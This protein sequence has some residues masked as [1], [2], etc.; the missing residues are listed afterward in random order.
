M[1]ACAEEDRSPTAD[2]LD[3]LRPD[4]NRTSLGLERSDVRKPCVEYLQRT[5]CVAAPASQDYFTSQIL[6][7]ARCDSWLGNTSSRIN[8]SSV[9][10]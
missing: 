10:G 1:A 5:A 2:G 7:T 4:K 6:V 9:I 8:L 3:A